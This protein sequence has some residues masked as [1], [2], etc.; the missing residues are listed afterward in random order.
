MQEAHIFNLS[1]P[2]LWLPVMVFTYISNED[3]IFGC[4]FSL[5]IDP[6]QTERVSSRQWSG[7]WFFFL[8]W[9]IQKFCK[10]KAMS[11]AAIVLNVKESFGWMDDEI[12]YCGAEERATLTSVV[13]WASSF[14]ACGRVSNT[15]I[16]N[17]VVKQRIYLC[18]ARCRARVF[19]EH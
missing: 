10:M 19:T 3:D 9:W 5:W 12:F 1:S 16:S 13:M 14:H 4:I 11:E 6:R 18:D 8:D 15:P 7:H 2:G 17:K